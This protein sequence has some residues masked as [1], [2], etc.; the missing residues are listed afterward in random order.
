M[1]GKSGN[2]KVI[3]PLFSWSESYKDEIPIFTSF[4][5]S[6][7]RKSLPKPYELNMHLLS[8]TEVHLHNGISPNEYLK[9]AMYFIPFLISDDIESLSTPELDHGRSAG[10]VIELIK[11]R[12]EHYKEMYKRLS[13]VYG[14][15]VII[16][17]RSL[18]VDELIN[19]YIN[20][21]Q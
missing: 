9:K 5:K 7:F 3:S 11:Y 15:P 6:Y 1:N 2:V 13:I 17:G 21:L 4:G 16:N 8:L 18:S 10:H 14:Q 20:A 12:M 19:H